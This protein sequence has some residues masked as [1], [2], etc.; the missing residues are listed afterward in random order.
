MYFWLT[1]LFDDS[2]YFLH[3]G[4]MPYGSQNQHGVHL[5][6]ISWALFLQCATLHQSDTHTFRSC[7]PWVRVLLWMEYQP[8]LESKYA[9][10]WSYFGRICMSV[11]LQNKLLRLCV[12]VYTIKYNEIRQVVRYLTVNTWTH[13]T[14]SV[15][16]SPSFTP[17]QLKLTHL[18]VPLP[19]TPTWTWKSHR[20]ADHSFCL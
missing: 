12:L 11:F 1:G 8:C 2:P 6:L 4:K 5:S 7:C 15:T 3:Y 19:R 16:S 18:D 13:F 20:R 14:F 17:R 9:A 10:L